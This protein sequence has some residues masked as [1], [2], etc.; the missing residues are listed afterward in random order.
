MREKELKNKIINFS[1]NNALW[2]GIVLISISFVPMYKDEIWVSLIRNVLSTL[3]GSFLSM[4]LVTIYYDQWTKHGSSD[5]ISSSLYLSSEQIE[6]LMRKLVNN[7]SPA[8]PIK[9]YPE[10]KTPEMPFSEDFIDDLKKTTVF[11]YSGVR[12]NIA[13]KCI[14]EVFSYK[15]IKILYFHFYIP[16]PE[17]KLL[18]NDDL[19]NMKASLICIKK[20]LINS[21]Y[22]HEIKLKFS[23]LNILPPFHLHQTDNK[24]W[25]AAVKLNSDGVPYPIS[26]LYEKAESDK[27]SNY[28][29]APMYDTLDKMMKVLGANADENYLI[30]INAQSNA[31]QREEAFCVKGKK[32]VIIELVNRIKK[33]TNN[34]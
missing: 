32:D 34:I 16:K 2:I 26:F 28:N 11:R 4:A 7:I 8:V 15:S 33:R 30:T 9:T 20:A 23:L 3:G 25:F 12:M 5:E 14:E 6:I 31:K 29:S 24:C 17:N 1:K 13:S 22:T 27:Q 21:S 19:D 10:S 18:S